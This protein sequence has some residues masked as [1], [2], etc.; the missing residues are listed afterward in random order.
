MAAILRH[1]LRDEL[2]LPHWLE[3]V[4]HVEGRQARILRID[5]NEASMLVEGHFMHVQIAGDLRIA[6]NKQPVKKLICPLVAAQ[7]I[8]EPPYRLDRRDE[9][10]ISIADKTH[11]TDEVPLMDRDSLVWER[12]DEKKLTRLIRC[13][14]ET[15]I[16]HDEPV[17]E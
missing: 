7:N 13:K 2:W 14:R 9:D 17:G 5:E 16:I 15:H 11:R 4:N 8:V 6:W 3:A 12:P 10:T 1:K